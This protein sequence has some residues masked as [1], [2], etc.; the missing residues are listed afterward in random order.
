MAML[1]SDKPVPSA[2]PIVAFESAVDRETSVS[3]CRRMRD[4][5]RFGFTKETSCSDVDSGPGRSTVVGSTVSIA[6]GST[7]RRIASSRVEPG[8]RVAL[9]TPDLLGDVAAGSTKR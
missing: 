7:S 9:A 5:A 4:P 2:R 8:R 6:S 1:P 3:G